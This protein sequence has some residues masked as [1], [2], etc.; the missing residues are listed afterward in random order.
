MW[1]KM[2]AA[3]QQALDAGDGDRGFHDAKLATAAF[4]ARRELPL[5]GGLRRQVEAGAG[6]VMALPVDAF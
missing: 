3:S 2:A 5:S 6:T 4:Y 1:L